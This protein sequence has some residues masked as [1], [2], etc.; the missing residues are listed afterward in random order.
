METH[1][2][3]RAVEPSLGESSHDEELD[4]A[5]LA[6]EAE[7]GPVKLL[8]LGDRRGHVVVER[9]WGDISPKHFT[10]VLMCGGEAHDERKAWW[11]ARA[12]RERHTNRLVAAADDYVNTISGHHAF[13]CDGEHIMAYVFS[14]RGVAKGRERAVLV[15]LRRA[16]IRWH[17]RE[18]RREERAHVLLSATGRRLSWS[19]S[20]RG[21]L[22]DQWVRFSEEIRDVLDDPTT[23]PVLV[24][25]YT[26]T[27][28]DLSDGVRQVH[29][30]TFNRPDALMMDYSHALNPRQLSVAELVLNGFD[31]PTIAADLEISRDTVKYHL[32]QIYKR[33]GISSRAEL[34]TILS[35][36]V[37]IK[38]TGCMTTAH[39]SNPGTVNGGS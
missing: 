31:N 33:V 29:L 20:A 25:P 26:A 18:H 9:S 10:N 35:H 14:A 6:L 27:I 11:C 19:H 30:V 37:G 16:L 17:A 4:T 7:V 22:E 1:S 15:E 2:P 36:H 21:L 28:A 23:P 5:I 3:D 39:S 34:V 32:K 12:P 8:C 38:L 13:L 24:G